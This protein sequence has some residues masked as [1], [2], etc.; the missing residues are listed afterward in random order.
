MIVATVASGYRYDLER[1][2][3]GRID[4]QKVN[5]VLDFGAEAHS[6][7]C[8]VDHVGRTDADH[9]DAEHLAR[10]RI[11]A[12]IVSSMRDLLRDRAPHPSRP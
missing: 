3:H 4:M 7:G 9:G 10:V 2:G 1:F 8:L 12:A 5:E 11:L 6:H